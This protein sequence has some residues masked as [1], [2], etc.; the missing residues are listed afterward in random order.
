MKI[1]KFK[2]ALLAGLAFVLE[3]SFVSGNAYFSLFPRSF[4]EMTSVFGSQV[5]GSTPSTSAFKMNGDVMLTSNYVFRGL[6]E[7]NKDP[8]LQASYFLNLGPQFMMGLWGSGVNY[9]DTEEHFMLRILAELKV[10]LSPTI[11]IN[12][13]YSSNKFFKS[14]TRDGTTT[15]LVLR[16]PSWIVG[17]EKESNWEGTRSKSDHYLF[18]FPWEFAPKWSWEN[19]LEYNKLNLDSYVSYLD[20]RSTIVYNAEPILYSMSASA[21]SK[22]N[23][24]D[25]RGQSFFIASI[26]AKF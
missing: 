24:F 18:G 3:K 20:I 23:Q 6:T 13:R 21:N 7:S 15:G 12:L 25:D 17:Y 2:L 5:A 8:V 14:S 11:K 9:S 1:T 10:E 16:T 19:T 22:P 26:M 4:A